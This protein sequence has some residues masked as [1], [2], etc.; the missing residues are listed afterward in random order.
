MYSI[1][2]QINN[3]RVLVY[4]ERKNVISKQTDSVVLTKEQ[5]ASTYFP[6]DID[7]VPEVHFEKV[8][9]GQGNFIYHGNN[10]DVL[11][12]LP[13]NSIDSCV[14]D[15][16][17]GLKFMNSKWDHDVP[18][19]EFWKEVYRVLKPGGYVLSF[20]GTRTY[21]RMVINVEDAGFEVRDQLMWVYG[22]GFPKS[23]NISKS[24]DKK[25]GNP[26]LTTEFA[27]D[28]KKA[29][30]S[31]G[32]SKTKADE[33][34]C[35]GT[36]L[37]S[38]Y[39]GRKN[40]IQL[41]TS[42]YMRKIADAFPELEKY[43]GLTM[44]AEREVIGKYEGDMG[45]LGGKR[46]GRLNGDI[47]IASTEDAKKWEGWGTN[48]KPA[49]E[50]ILMARKPFKGSVANNVL[51]WNTGGINIDDCRV[52]S[53]KRTIPIFSNDKKDDATL[54]G[55]HPTIQ[56]HREE[57][58]LGRFPA[59]IFFD[60]EAGKLLDEQSGITSQGHWSKSKTTGFGSFGNGKSIYNGVGKKDNIK[61]GASRF[62]YC[63]KPSKKEREEGLD[64]EPRIINGRDE[65]QDNRNVP[66]KLR[67]SKRMNTHSTV[68][69]VSLMQYLIRLVTPKGGITIDPFA[70]S[71]TSPKATIRE[72]NFKFIAIEKEKEYFDIAVARC[73]YEY[74]Q[75]I[76]KAA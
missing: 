63:P 30:E 62:F 28:L 66:Q 8:E 54:F 37:Y 46:L 36:S 7:I 3:R 42:N 69:P 47:T 72:G 68:K 9:I 15:P 33:M 48:L 64:N 29:R 60:E 59:N 45:G 73:Q 27:K 17:Y 57:T 21:H 51:L 16:P 50:P 25:G 20:G 32:L 76:Q 31:K 38:W 6:D 41:P 65:G 40:G 71:G 56:H 55:L 70:G 39:E 67:N 53:E 12:T 75:S 5:I 14:T 35:C 13:D 18:S 24:I 11:R 23:Q 19:V 22:S 34:F 61:S 49:H 26:N 10:I 43:V 52:N 44:E 4:P 1:H 2:D 74:E 58:E